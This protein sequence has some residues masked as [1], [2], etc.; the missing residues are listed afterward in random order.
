MAQLDDVLAFRVRVEDRDVLVQCAVHGCERIIQL[1]AVVAAGARIRIEQ[2]VADEHRRQQ[3]LRA[4]GRQKLL[5]FHVPGVDGVGFPLA[6]AHAGGEVVARQQP[7]HEH[8][9]ERQE[10]RRSN[11]DAFEPLAAPHSRI[12]PCGSPVQ[13]RRPPAPASP[14]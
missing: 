11:G 3:H 6:V 2:R 5:R 9:A 12:L 14:G 13:W 4:N 10:Q 8:Q 1:A 7:E